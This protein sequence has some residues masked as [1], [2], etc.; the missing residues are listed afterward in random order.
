MRLGH[1]RKTVSKSTFKAGEMSTDNQVGNTLEKIKGLYEDNLVQH[2]I[3]SKAVGW[4]DEQSQLLR[5][6]KL[7]HV[8]SAEHEGYSVNDWGCGYAAM[9]DY[10][11]EHLSGCVKYY[12]YD[13][14]AEM[15]KR[16]RELHPQSEMELIQSASV[17]AKAD[18]TFVSGTF[19]VRFNE[20]NAAWDTYIKETLLALAQQTKKGLA[21]NLLTTYVDW[22]QENLFYAD[23]LEY[24]D[25][26]KRNLSRNVSLIHDY[27]LYEWTMLVKF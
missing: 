26:C 14:S 21:F 13:I 1:S 24:F 4:K 17:T 7:S 22:K 5:F 19:N 3:S 20:S 11:D 10:L 9:Y 18:Y 12:G 23:P 25:F 8:I 2:G 27:P 16:A 15:L 6:Q